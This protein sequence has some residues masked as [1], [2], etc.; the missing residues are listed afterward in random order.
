MRI[1]DHLSRSF[2]SFLLDSIESP[3]AEWGEEAE[4]I[5]DLFINLLLAFNLHFEMPSDNPVMAVLGQYGT[6]KVF[7][8]KVMLLV[9]RGGECVM[10]SQCQS[11]SSS[12]CTF[13]SGDGR[14][15]N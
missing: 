4:D 3:A 2:I 5:T 12:S 15:L 10:Q 14:I 13:M 6:A 7:T 8:E 9:N 11:D 1:A